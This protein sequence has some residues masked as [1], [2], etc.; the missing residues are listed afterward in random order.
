M[1]HPITFSLTQ[2]CGIAFSPGIPL[3]Q[4]CGVVFSKHFFWG[5]SAELYS[6]NIFFRETMR[7]CIP[8]L[9]FEAIM[10]NYILKTLHLRQLSRVVFP[11]FPFRQLCGVVFWQHFLF[12]VIMRNC[13]LKIF[14][15]RQFYWI[16]FSKH[17]FWGNS[18]E[19]YS[20]NTSFE[21]ILQN[22]I[23]KTFHFEAILQNCILTLSLLGQLCRVAFPQMSKDIISPCE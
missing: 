18:A 8:T 2:F 7:N 4:L 1:L 20:Q 14:P 3:R 9:S 15:L 13:I 23:L 10:Q 11:H 19:F 16:V 12:E 6:Q 22:R 5:N 21:A 17:F